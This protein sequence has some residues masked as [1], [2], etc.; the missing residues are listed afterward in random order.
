MPRS[1]SQLEPVCLAN[2]YEDVVIRS[3]PDERAT[4]EQHKLQ[5]KKVQPMYPTKPEKAQTDNET[6][7]TTDDTEVTYSLPFHGKPNGSDLKYKDFDYQTLLGDF[8]YNQY[9]D[10][11][12]V[13]LKQMATVLQNALKQIQGNMQDPQEVCN[14]QE[15]N[16]DHAGRF[17]DSKQRYQNEP[18]ERQDALKSALQQHDQKNDSKLDTIFESNVYEPIPE[19]MD[20]N[21]IPVSDE[22]PP[23]L[24]I[25]RRKLRLPATPKKEPAVQI[26]VNGGEFNR[27]FMSLTR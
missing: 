10:Y 18:R 1:S 13:Q 16:Q 2:E 8:T 15:Q 27:F 7:F 25:K 21:A 24:P 9:Q 14:P 23:P 11:T 6:Q 19:A 20:K 22:I 12:D 26:N 4:N 3:P 17:T 5:Q